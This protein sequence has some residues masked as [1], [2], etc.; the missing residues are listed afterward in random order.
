MHARLTQPTQMGEAPDS[1]IFAADPG[2]ENAVS[3]TNIFSSIQIP[4]VASV[5]PK[6]FSTNTDNQFDVD[7]QDW[8]NLSLEAT[9]L[10]QPLVVPQNTGVAHP[11]TTTHRPAT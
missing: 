5:I 7:T 4:E 3:K 2:F 11:N 1:S 6:H 10:P 8:T 9:P